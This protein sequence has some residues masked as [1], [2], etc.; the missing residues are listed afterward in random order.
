MEKGWTYQVI[1]PVPLSV[2]K[3]KSLRDSGVIKFID[4]YERLFLEK[5]NA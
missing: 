1:D 3:V 2:D 5:Y 4:R